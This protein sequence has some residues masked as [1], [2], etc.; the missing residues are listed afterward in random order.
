MRKSHL[1]VDPGNSEAVACGRTVQT[2]GTTPFATRVTCLTCKGKPAWQEAYR[3]EME[4]RD[5]AFKA[6]TPRQVRHMMNNENMVCTCGGD[7]WR[8]K[9]RSLFS[10]HFVCEACGRDVFPPTETGMCT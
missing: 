1:L 4:A 6:Q 7:L 9:P 10:F 2:W 8:E 3:S 5:A